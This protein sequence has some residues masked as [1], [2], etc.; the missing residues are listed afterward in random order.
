MCRMTVK[1]TRYSTIVGTSK[2][3]GQS[4]CVCVCVCVCVCECVCVGVSVCVGG[5]EFAHNL[6]DII[7]TSLDRYFKMHINFYTQSYIHVLLSM[8]I[9][10]FCMNFYAETYQCTVNVLTS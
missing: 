6:T 5:G 3:L 10:T 7:N 1:H 8:C 9:D 4:L 2:S